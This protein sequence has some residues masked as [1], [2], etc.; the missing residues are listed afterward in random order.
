M[1]NTDQLELRTNKQRNLKASQQAE[2]VIKGNIKN[3]TAIFIR[4]ILIIFIFEGDCVMIVY[5]KNIEIMMS[6]VDSIRANT[7]STGFI[8]N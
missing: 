3:F 8:A 7:S 2:R 1:D 6:V 5:I 4:L